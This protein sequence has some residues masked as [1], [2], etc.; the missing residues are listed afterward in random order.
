[1]KIFLRINA[2]EILKAF[3]SK[4]LL[5]EHMGKGKIKEHTNL[6]EML[7]DQICAKYD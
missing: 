6:L 3:I 4:K 2:P 7:W 1:M 5:K